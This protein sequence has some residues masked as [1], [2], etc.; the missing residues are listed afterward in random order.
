[1]YADER[2][3]R[4][5]GI[6]SP[7]TVIDYQPYEF[8]RLA[9][10]ELLLV[11]VACGLEEYSSEE[12]LRVFQPLDRMLDLLMARQIEMVVQTGVPLPLLLG[13][14]GHRA[15]MDH[16]REYTGLPVTSQL[17]NVLASTKHLGLKNI[18]IAN[19]W[20]DAMNET[21]V[22]Y[23][24]RE[25][26]SVAG[27]C[28]RSLSPRQSAEIKGDGQ[29]RLVYELAFN[30]CK[31]HPEADGLY[32]GGGS[33]KAQPTAEQLERDLNL[34]V[35]SNVNAMVWNLST[36]TGLRRPIEGHGRLL[37]AR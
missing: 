32:V 7:R 10:S 12:V 6:L 4:R 25:G 9:P 13:I 20:T 2:S 36:L 27:V 33:W 29:A 1:M 3:E 31:S 17:D 16:I 21:L 26:I 24:S 14:D 23:F 37:D 28:N 11:M 18:V 5:I 19:K 22:R 35:I 30:G 8:Y 15:V 34:P